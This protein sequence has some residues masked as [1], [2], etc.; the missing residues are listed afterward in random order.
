MHL[1]VR[2]AGLAD[3]DTVVALRL[4]LLRAARRNPLYERLRPD[5]TRQARRLFGAQLEA[6]D[7]VVFLAECTLAAAG[8]DAARDVAP[9]VVGIIRCVESW[10]SPLLDPPRY[11]YVSS[12]Y[13]VPRARRCGVLRALV[14]EVRAWCHERG[15]PE[16]RLHCAV[17]SRAGN[18]AWDA[19]GF[20]VVEHVRRRPIDS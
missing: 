6:K 16:M 3:L 9:E 17:E 10:G 20:D 15:L 1:T 8:A 2:P 11:G 7:E 12:A 13:V 19:L 4:A 14:A 18:A 5:A